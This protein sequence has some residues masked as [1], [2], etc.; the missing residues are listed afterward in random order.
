[1][2]PELKRQLGAQRAKVSYVIR[3]YIRQSGYTG[4]S[5]AEAIGISGAHVSRTI[6]GLSHSG[7]V[8]DALRDLGV[9]EEYL[10]D[11]RRVTLPALAVNRETREGV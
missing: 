3:H 10:Y 6:V 11:P 1:M 7:A 8:L 2:T 4:D 9:P 5:L